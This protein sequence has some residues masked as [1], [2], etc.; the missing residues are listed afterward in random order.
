MRLRFLLWLVL[1]R[2]P[3]K[4]LIALAAQ[5]IVRSRHR[6]FDE[7]AEFGVRRRSI[8]VGLDFGGFNCRESEIP[9][10]RRTPVPPAR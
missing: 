8:L 10:E 3:R 6:L 5:E 1:A 4:G 2:F 7:T 9:T